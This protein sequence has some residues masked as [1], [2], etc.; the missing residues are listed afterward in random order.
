M[1]LSSTVTV[2]NA[3]KWV[4]TL[5]WIPYIHFS[6]VLVSN[7]TKMERWREVKAKRTE[8]IHIVLLR[9]FYSN[10][11][12]NWMLFCSQSDSFV[13]TSK[14]DSIPFICSRACV[15]LAAL[16]LEEKTT[17]ELDFWFR[18][19]ILWLSF[20][21]FYKIVKIFTTLHLG[22]DGDGDG[23]EP[24][25]RTEP[26]THRLGPIHTRKIEWFYSMLFNFFYLW[27]GRI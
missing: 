8:R 17:F 21:W 7:E 14:C 19:Q 24:Q 13:I 1:L 10:F 12:E 18:I 9:H 15:I 22:L 6:S 23:S 5:R 3:T 26:Q 20:T 11:Q 16:L 27:L 4:F 25:N 2:K